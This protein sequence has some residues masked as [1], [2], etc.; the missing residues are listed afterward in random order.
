MKLTR[1]ERAALRASFQ[2]M[3]PADKA[4]YIWEY[5]KLPIAL[6][7][8]A[9]AFVCSTVYR[10][11]TK[12]EVLVYS[13]LINV[14]AGD[15]LASRLDEGF[16]SAEGTDPKRAEVCLYQGLYLS[17]DPSPE[18][19]QYGYAS[20]LKLMAAIEAKQMDVV[21]MNKEAYDIYSRNGYL[22]ELDSLLSQDEALYRALEPSLTANTVV[23]EDNAIEYALNEASQYLAV[24]E[25]AMNGLD[26]SAFPMFQSAG[27]SEPV[28]LGVIANSPR[29]SAV[30]QY[31]EYLADGRS[32]EK[33]EVD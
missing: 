30:I 20:R 24:T 6:G 9:L 32:V 11:A 18:N 28:Y 15:E 1:Q 10:Q 27:F 21:L 5:Y 17:E 13:A 19:H 25:E 2:E 3:G 31:I 23:L 26:V 16:I 33:S 29:L 8:L 4:G 22:L 12:K 14:S 7:L